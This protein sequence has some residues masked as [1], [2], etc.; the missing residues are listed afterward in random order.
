M[1]QKNVA[2]ITNEN[3]TD[4]L[5]NLPNIDESLYRLEEYI[6]NE[7]HAIYLQRF[8]IPYIV[9]YQVVRV[10]YIYL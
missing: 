4:M 5:C 1:Y 6:L 2:I 3:I 9:I 10:K 8:L 7:T